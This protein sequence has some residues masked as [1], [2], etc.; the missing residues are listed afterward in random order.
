MDK[1]FAFLSRSE[2]TSE[3]VRQAR[4]KKSEC[5][6]SLREAFGVT[7]KDLKAFLADHKDQ[8]S[9]LARIDRNLESLLEGQ[10]EEKALSKGLGA[11]LNRLVTL[12]TVEHRR[13]FLRNIHRA[14]KPE[15]AARG[16]RVSGRESQCDSPETELPHL[17]ERQNQ[18]EEKPPRGSSGRRQTPTPRPEISIQMIGNPHT[19]AFEMPE[20]LTYQSL[21]KRLGLPLAPEREPESPATESQASCLDDQASSSLPSGSRSSSRLTYVL[22]PLLVVGAASFLG[23][24]AR[25]AIR[26]RG[27]FSH[28]TRKGGR[29]DD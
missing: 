19:P 7:V 24:A 21:R 20:G 9:R 12:P 6:E 15:S 10:A 29:S 8:R 25:A 2:R 13:R 17:V 26:R 22:S 4:A 16:P 3:R 14:L 18:T 5:H 23:V 28:R 11:S 1:D 27:L